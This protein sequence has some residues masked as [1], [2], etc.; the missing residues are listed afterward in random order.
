MQ[1]HGLWSSYDAASRA[2]VL[3]Q[4][5]ANG[6]QWVRID[7]S[8]DMLQ[9]DNSGSY[10][11]WG[12]SQ[13]DT[14]LHE[15]DRRGLKILVTFWQTPGWANDGAGLRALPHNPGAFAKAAGFAANRWGGLVDG[16]EIWNEP[17]SEDFLRGADPSAYT[18]L[19][20]AAYPAIKRADAGSPVVFGGLM[21]NDDAWLAR[22]YRAGAHGCFD[23]MATHPYLGPSDA[24]PE[25]AMDGHNPWRL[26]NVTAVRSQ[27]A[28]NG[29]AAKPIWFT[30]FGWST[31]GSK[32]ADL[33]DRP[34]T[35]TQ[36]ADYLKRAV[37]FT[38]TNYPYVSRMLWYSD[39][40]R[41]TGDPHEDGYGLLH[42]DLS[43]KPA[44]WALKAASSR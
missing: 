19:L 41:S 22:A 36:Q 27:M 32:D 25:A 3:D 26:R 42:T 12:V 29:D 1:F 21:Y 2:K 28:A 33:W 4:F 13:V 8:W 44:L 31:G 5:A 24:P 30:E 38:R 9:P 17:N 40:D 6:A 14:V 43:P 23:A 34:V 7:V 16:W 11:P 18:R 37:A 39:I 35:E 15:A 20:C 10:H